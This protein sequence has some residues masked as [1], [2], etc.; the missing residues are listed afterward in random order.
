MCVKVSTQYVT[1]HIWK[2]VNTCSFGYTFLHLA[3]GGFFFPTFDTPD[4]SWFLNME[5]PR[6][7]TPGEQRRDKERETQQS[8]DTHICHKMRD[9]NC[10]GQQLECGFEGERKKKGYT[11]TTNGS[12]G[13]TPPVFLTSPHLYTILVPEKFSLPLM[14]QATF[15][16]SF[17]PPCMALPPGEET[18]LDS[19]L[20]G[21]YLYLSNRRGFPY[22]AD[23]FGMGQWMVW[24]NPAGMGRISRLFSYYHF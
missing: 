15:F 22:E 3:N 18:R 14:G 6:C 2:R 10:Y 24:K 16:F 13:K 5:S 23:H 12:T 21:V 7:K 9:H 4:E 8:R 20:Y 1:I 11:S 17:F 19:V